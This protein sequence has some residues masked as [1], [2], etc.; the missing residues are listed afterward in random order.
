MYTPARRD[1]VGEVRHFWFREAPRWLS[2]VPDSHPINTLVF[3]AVTQCP[4]TLAAADRS[5]PGPLADNEGNPAQT[6]VRA[7]RLQ[8]AGELVP[9]SFSAKGLNY[10]KELTCLYLGDFA[11][12]R[13]E[14][15]SLEFDTL[16][17]SYLGAFARRCSEYLPANKVEMTRSECA[18]EQYTENAVARGLPA[19]IIR[20][21]RARGLVLGYTL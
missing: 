19:S 21:P 2:T 9:V 18:R 4:A 5:A 13:L 1:A 6:N 15:D 16:F 17:G 8:T 10:E 14:R 12:A 20:F 7:G 11:H 3:G